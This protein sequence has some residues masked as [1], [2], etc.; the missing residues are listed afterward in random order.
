MA[1]PSLSNG[2]LHFFPFIFLALWLAIGVVLWWRSG[3]ARLMIQFP[4][5]TSGLLLRL[6]WVSG[7]M[8]AGVRMGGILRLEV[9]QEGLRVGV[10]SLGRLLLPM[11][12]DFFVPWQEILVTRK[13][14]MIGLLPRFNLAG[15]SPSVL[16]P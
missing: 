3:W 9:C 7:F 10:V 5:H 15:S 2:L 16:S 13:H 6:R 12:R 8:G 11:F 4:N 1:M 14:W